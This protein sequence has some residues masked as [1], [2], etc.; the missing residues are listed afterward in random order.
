MSETF[1]QKVEDKLEAHMMYLCPNWGKKCAECTLCK[2][3]VTDIL[4]AYKEVV[5][6]MPLSKVPL[7]YGDIASYRIGLE[8][9]RLTCKEHLLKEGE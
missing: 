7:K 1:K 2:Q 9:Q 8:T 5:E 6:G 4:A 3:L